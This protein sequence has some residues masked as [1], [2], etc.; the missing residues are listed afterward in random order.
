MSLVGDWNYPTAIRFG[1]ARVVEL[2]GACR[3]MGIHRPLLV[4]D[5]QLAATSMVAEATAACV[6]EGLTVATFSEFGGDPTGSEVDAGAG[7]ARGHR[8][9]GVIAFGGGS[10]LDAGKAVAFI[11]GQSRPLWD[12]EDIGD[13]WRRADE[14]AI[15]QVIAVPTTAGTG[16]EVGRASVIKDEAARV[17]RIVFHPRMLPALV[18]ADP[19]LSVGLPPHLTAAVGMDALS[20][21]LE[22]YFA[23][24]FHPFA[25]GI[26]V[27][28]A[29][30]IKDWLPLAVRDGANLEAR[31]HMLAAAEAGAA[32]FQRGLG[33]MH[34]LAHP[35]GALYGVHHGLLNAVLMPYVLTAN[36]PAI[37][38]DA[39]MLARYLDLGPG[40]EDLMEWILSLRRT[41]GIPHT[42]A[43]VGIP[44]DELALIARMAMQDPSAAGNPIPFREADYAEIARRALA[45]ELARD[46][47]DA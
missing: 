33:A 32:A 47:V 19:A 22:A 14:T 8:A 1:V 42:L 45:G 23:P 29:R 2:A 43:E 16:S 6:H 10:A 17:K 24:G 27:E 31:S 44:G 18:I 12:F 25:R 41:I 28:G 4:T 34:A 39:A 30:L 15:L 26:A 35:L 7:A 11:A 37:A 21:N 9:D 13:N 40:A 46:R 3:E 36:M 38:K 5:R 20:H